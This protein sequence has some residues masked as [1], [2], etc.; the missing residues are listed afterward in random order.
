MKNM[1]YSPIFHQ[2]I[3]YFICEILI[4]LLAEIEYNARRTNNIKE[5]FL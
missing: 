1:K 5:C 3:V 2:N 4:Y